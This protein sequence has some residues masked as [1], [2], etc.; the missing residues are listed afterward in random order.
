MLSLM[1][2]F[3]ENRVIGKDNKLPWRLPSDLKNF[4][5]IT[6]G[7][8]VVMGRKTFDS[9]GKPLPNRFNVVISSNKEE[10]TLKYQDVPPEQLLF[11]NSLNGTFERLRAMSDL[12]NHNPLFEEFVMIGGSTIYQAAL[13][14]VDKLY[15]TRIHGSCQGDTFFPEYAQNEWRVVESSMVVDEKSYFEEDTEKKPLT[16]TFEVLE[17][18]R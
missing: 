10:L 7:K 1:V 6:T 11:M 18:V 17:R 5:K 15:L 14:V 9:I 4:K 3:T 13:P 2:A 12:K 8:T 16:Y